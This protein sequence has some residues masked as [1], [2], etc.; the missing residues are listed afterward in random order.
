LIHCRLFI[1]LVYSSGKEKVR[2][3]AKE[4]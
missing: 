4:I 1:F 2:I 3:N